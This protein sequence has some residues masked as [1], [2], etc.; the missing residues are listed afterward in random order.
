MV[1]MT[2]LIALTEFVDG[3]TLKVVKIRARSARDPYPDMADRMGIRPGLELTRVRYDEEEG[4]LICRS[5]DV[6]FGLP[7]EM[8]ER[9]VAERTSG[10]RDP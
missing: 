5:Q 6:E 4:V 9:I 2:D 10:L 7:L 3:E 8:C 1:A